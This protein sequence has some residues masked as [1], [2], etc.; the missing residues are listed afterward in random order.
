MAD[1]GEVEG[2]HPADVV[3]VQVNLTQREA[4]DTSAGLGPMIGSAVNFG[5][6]QLPSGSRRQDFVLECVG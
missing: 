2:D 1:V 6:L 3:P 4:R 5:Y